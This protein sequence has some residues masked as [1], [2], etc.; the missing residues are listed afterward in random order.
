MADISVAPCIILNYIIFCRWY[1]C[2]LHISLPTFTITDPTKHFNLHIIRWWSSTQPMKAK[3]K[4]F[5]NWNI[6][7]SFHSQ[8][9]RWSQINSETCQIYKGF[10]ICSL[11][12]HFVRYVQ[13]IKVKTHDLNGNLLCFKSL[14]FIFYK[15]KIFSQLYVIR[16]TLYI[17]ILSMQLTTYYLLLSMFTL[18]NSKHFF[19]LKTNSVDKKWDSQNEKQNF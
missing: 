10:P 14:Y 16:Y 18:F 7:E 12:N 11:F 2:I 1:K 8:N 4:G 13:L 15:I 17:Q 6:T 5:K 19:F 9:L 3:Q